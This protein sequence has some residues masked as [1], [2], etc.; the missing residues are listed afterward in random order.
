MLSNKAAEKL[1]LDM[2]YV[3]KQ[4]GLQLHHGLSVPHSLHHKQGKER[5][6]RQ[7]LK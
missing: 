6:K 1:W 3:K 7:D 4:C 5:K 2:D